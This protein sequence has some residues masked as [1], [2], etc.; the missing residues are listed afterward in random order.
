MEKIELENITHIYFLGIGGIGMS[1]IAFYLHEKGKVISGYDR[2]QTALTKKLEAL[3]MAIHYEV[4]PGRIPEQIDLVVYTPAIPEDQEERLLLQKRRVPMFK[5]SEILQ[6]IL[7]EG[8]VIAVAGTHGKTSTS[9][10]LAHILYASGFEV[11]AF[12]G[13]VLVNYGTNYLNNGSKWFVVEADEYD[14]SFWRLNP[15]IAVIQAIDPDH[16][17]IYGSPAEMVKAYRAFTER[18][19]NGGSLWISEGA[20]HEHMD[21]EWMNQLEAKGVEVFMFG[22]GQKCHA[23]ADEIAT[24]G[25]DW[26]FSLSW[27]GEVVQIRSNLPGRYNVRNT[28]AAA[29]VASKLGL[30]WN[31]IVAAI[32][33]FQGIERRYEVKFRT[34]EVTLVDDY[35][36]HPEEISAVIRATRE[37]YPGMTITVV[38]QPHLFTRTRDFALGFAQSLDLADRVYILDI[39]PAREIPIPGVTS[40]TILT[41]MKNKNGNTISLEELPQEFDN[42]FSGVLLMLGAGDLHKA[43]PAIIERIK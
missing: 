18:V 20:Y 38:F 31:E 6:L 28:A 1:A 22:E 13:G 32:G 17:D 19:S 12:I 5:R 21:A 41:S 34:N 33:S 10:S 27:K 7:S 4:D 24:D 39:Y 35:A 30:G 3:G 40:N 23:R 36:H 42:Q 29:V 15:E 26:T 37:S 11:T 43:I 2:E 25:G 8:R 16:L 14:R 9:A